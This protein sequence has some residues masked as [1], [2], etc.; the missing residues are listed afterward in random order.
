MA[1]GRSFTRFALAAIGSGLSTIA[2]AQL[3][4]Q[5]YGVADLSYGRFEPSGSVRD[6]RVNSNSMSASFIGFTVKNGLDDGWTPGA[7][8][9][10]FVRFQDLE[11]GRKDNDP[12]LSRNT[13]VSL[14]S[15][16]GSV[17]VGRLQTYLFD[18]T[19]RFNALGNAIGFSPSVRGVFQDGNIEG[20]QGDFYWDRA[21]SY[22][23]PNLDGVT[24][25]A[26]AARG[27]AA[28]RGDYAGASVVW[29]SGLFAGTLSGQR[30]H[31]NDGIHDATAENTWQLGTTYTFG[32]AKLFGQ[33][34]LIND[35]GLDVRSKISSIGATVPAGP[36]SIDLQGAFTRA[37]GP[38]V[39][40]KHT[41]VAVAYV[42]PY[43]SLID[44]YVAG[45]D[46]RVRGQTRGVSAA[47][48]VRVRFD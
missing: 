47:L 17:R 44:L 29:A 37:A 45:L 9:E 38:A 39:D 8:L 13:F 2:S 22:S 32:W 41:A 43:D 40:R 19:V 15:N 12:I 30:V 26:M 6:D 48:G 4:T 31:V 3:S 28:H 46:D 16:Y 23:T 11:T 33:F 20:V 27:A 35:I 14:G 1:L 25:N 24:V 5:V 18:S 36:G 21:L 42:F 7:T 10:T 34:T